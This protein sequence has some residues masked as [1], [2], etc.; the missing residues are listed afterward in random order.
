M[1]CIVAKVERIAL[2]DNLLNEF[3]SNI[4]HEN[5]S[6]LDVRRKTYEFS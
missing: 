3:A 6:L 4:R 1:T 5:T 2:V